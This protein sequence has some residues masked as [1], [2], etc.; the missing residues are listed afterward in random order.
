[1]RCS[2]A[3][4]T[5][6]KNGLNQWCIAKNGG[7]YT[8]RGVAKGLKVPCL[9]MITEVSIRCRKNREGG[10]LR[11][12]AYTPQYTTGLNCMTACHCHGRECENMDQL[13]NCGVGVD[14]SVDGGDEALLDIVYDDDVDW[15]Y[16]EIVV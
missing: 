9:F 1:M 3:L 8:Q 4:C 11:I 6:R 12:P 5:C 13:K 14:L 7:G 15:I 10:I 16:E 2:S